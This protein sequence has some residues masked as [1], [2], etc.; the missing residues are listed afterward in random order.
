MDQQLT[1]QTILCI[2]KDTTTAVPSVQLLLVILSTTAQNRSC[3]QSG[4][5]MAMLGR[6]MQA[7]NQEETSTVG[8]PQCVEWIQN[9]EWCD[10]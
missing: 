6:Q 7:R 3:V 9:Q 10:L 5:H 2:Y 4:S 8:N 1:R